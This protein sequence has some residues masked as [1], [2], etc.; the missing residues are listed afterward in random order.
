MKVFDLHSDLFTDIAWRRE[1]GETNVFDT[2]HYP[3]LKAGGVDALICVFWVEPKFRNQ[4]FERFQ[5][6]FSYV[7]EDLKSSRHL[8]IQDPGN[9][10]V[11][12]SDKVSV[13][14]GTEGLTFLEEWKGTSLQ[15]KIENGFSWLSDEKVNHAIFSWNEHNFLAT[16]TGAVSSQ[17]N[18]LTDLGQFALKQG[19]INNWVVDVTHLDE[20]SFLDIYHLSDQAI[21][22][23]HSNSRSICQHERNLTDQ[24]IKA[25]AAR[26][27]I[28]GLNAYGEFVHS[29]TPNVD[30]FI[31]HAIHIANLVGY[32]YI[33]FGFDFIDYL[34]DYDLGGTPM[35]T[36]T[37]G[38]E[39]ASKIPELLFRMEQRGFSRKEMEAISFDN[40]NQFM[41]K[42]FDSENK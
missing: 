41:Q 37:N 26:D 42:R 22:A 23:S 8:V 19:E 1:R 5:R 30:H 29:E 14:L 35:R 31:D 32:E 38:L 15:A 4:A 17:A 21:M 27:G 10:K 25:I 2:V 7:M 20:A 6:I 24:Q 36:V 12:S 11:V 18:G 3:Y 39:D 9:P 16:G 33:G 40:A 28:I 13:Y 34:K